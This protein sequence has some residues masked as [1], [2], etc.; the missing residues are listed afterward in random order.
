[1]RGPY[2]SGARG[3]WLKVKCHQRSEFIA[4]SLAW[5]PTD[6]TRITTWLWYQN[7]ARPQDQGVVFT[8]KGQPVGPITQNLAGPNNDNSQPIKDMV[9]NAQVEHDLSPDLKVHAK[10]LTHTFTG[11]EDAIR[12][13]TVSKTNTIAPYFDGS[14]FNDWRYR[15][16]I[17][18]G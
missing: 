14:N 18:A 16:V 7:L 13:S 12:W 1:M 17:P 8:F 11:Y 3:V 9:Y 2:V 10:F 6:Q 5:N 4:P 15:T